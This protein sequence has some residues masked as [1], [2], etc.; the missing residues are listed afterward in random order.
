MA[1]VRLVTNKLVN[2]IVLLIPAKITAI[3]STS[4]EPIPVYLVADENGVIN[5]QP[6]V[7][8]ALLE[9]LVK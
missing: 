5:V 7:T 8:K 2:D 1:S 9:H 6:A 4:C 3:I